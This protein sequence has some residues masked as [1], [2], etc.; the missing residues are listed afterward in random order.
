MTKVLDR[1]LTEVDKAYIAGNA[2]IVLGGPNDLIQTITHDE[3]EKLV[4]VAIHDITG[5]IAA[6]SKTSLYIYKPFG[7]DFDAPRVSPT[8]KCIQDTEK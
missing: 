7:H 6:A 4:T 8:L 1:V 3:D 2:L 5:K